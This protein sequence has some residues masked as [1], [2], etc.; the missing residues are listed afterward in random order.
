MRVFS[1]VR[2]T[3]TRT[4]SCILLCRIFFSFHINITFL[5]L[6]YSPPRC[7]LTT[8][9]PP[10]IGQNWLAMACGSTCESQDRPRPSWSGDSWNSE[11][12]WNSGSHSNIFTHTICIVHLEVST[13]PHGLKVVTQSSECWLMDTI[14]HQSSHCL[15]LC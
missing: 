9:A 1:R 14:H 7:Q 6:L 4:T 8:P 3:K 12:I 2:H 5:P 10:I 15:P 11:N 13:S